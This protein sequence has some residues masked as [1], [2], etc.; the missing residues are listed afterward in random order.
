VHWSTGELATRTLLDHET[1]LRKLEGNKDVQDF[2]RAAWYPENKRD[3]KDVF[4]I[5]GVKEWTDADV[6]AGSTKGYSVRGK[7]T[8]PV[9]AAANLPTKALDVGGEIDNADKKQVSNAG[10][11]EGD[12]VF[13]VQ[14]RRIKK[15]SGGKLKLDDAKRLGPS[16]FSGED[17]FEDDSATLKHRDGVQ[18]AGAPESGE[19]KGSSDTSNRL[20]PDTESKGR[21]TLDR[22]VATVR[23]SN[24]GAVTETTKSPILNLEL[25]DQ[26]DENYL[27]HGDEEYGRIDLGHDDILFTRH[28]EGDE[29]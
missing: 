17:G 13:A 26:L 2:I 8:V 19:E 16:T 5:V 22:V 25:D 18:N 11:Y 20:T 12:A 10:V 1:Y 23:S 7:G 29:K 21:Q 14:Y 24:T 6:T 3:K 28:S 27:E 15:P 4:L 9:G